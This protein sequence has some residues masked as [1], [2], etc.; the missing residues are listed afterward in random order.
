M[1]ANGLSDPRKTLQHSSCESRLSVDL[2]RKTRATC[3]AFITQAFVTPP[4]LKVISLRLCFRKSCARRY[5][6]RRVFSSVCDA[7]SV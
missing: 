3:H 2:W 4:V 6:W 7:I 5:G 1:V